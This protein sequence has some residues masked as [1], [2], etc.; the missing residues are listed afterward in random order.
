M[1]AAT[2]APAVRFLGL[3][4]CVEDADGGPVSFPLGLLYPYSHDLQRLC[5]SF[6]AP[7]QEWP[8]AE[9]RRTRAS[10][11]DDVL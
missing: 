3:S 10:H 6:N 5:A 1:S 4:E 7:S 9:R 8:R 2:A 11:G